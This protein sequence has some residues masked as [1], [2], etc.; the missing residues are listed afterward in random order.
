MQGELGHTGA[1]TEQKLLTLHTFRADLK[2]WKQKQDTN[3]KPK[4]HNSQEGH[5]KTAAD[6]PKWWH[7]TY[8]EI[9]G[10]LN[11]LE[12]I[13][14]PLRFKPSLLRKESVGAG[15]EEGKIS[16]FPTLQDKDFSSP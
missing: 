9:W 8:T 2:E 7:D 11:I 4:F 12:M 13:R 1:R 10:Y 3:K 15:E 14:S 16:R 5:R 6:L